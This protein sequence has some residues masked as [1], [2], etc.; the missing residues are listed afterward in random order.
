MVK[1]ISIQIC[2]KHK[3]KKKFVVFTVT[4][5]VKNGLVGLDFFFGN[6]CTFWLSLCFTSIDFVSKKEKRKVYLLL[7]ASATFVLFYT[8]DVGSLVSVNIFSKMR[9]KRLQ[10][11]F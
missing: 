10:S 11:G 8:F 6:K 1:E 9:K 3:V 2:L 7:I 5:Q 4:C